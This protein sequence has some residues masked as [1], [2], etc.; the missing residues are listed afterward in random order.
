MISKK[1]GFSNEKPVF[2]SRTEMIIDRYYFGK[3]NNDEK[4]IY[5][6]IYNGI[7]EYRE[8]V[9]VPG[10]QLSN[11]LVGLIYYFVL[12]DNPFFFSIGEYAMHHAVDG[13]KIKITSLFSR[14]EEEAGRKK[15]EIII[16]DILYDPMIIRMN[17][18]EKEKYVHDY[19]IKNVK[20][21]HTHGNNGAFLNPYTVY[22]A[23]IEH[24]AVCEGI[25]KATKLLLNAM[26]IKCIVVSGDTD[27]ED[28]NHAWNIVKIGEAPY[29]LDVTYDMGKSLHSGFPH[30]DYFNLSDKVINRKIINQHLL[31]QCETMDM[32]Y[33]EKNRGIVSS[34]TELRTVF[35]EAINKR[36]SVV[37][38]K[39]DRSE[40]SEFKEEKSA[41]KL[42]ER[43]YF[44]V[45][46]GLGVSSSIFIDTTGFQGTCTIEITYS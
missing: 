38:I 14:E 41:K 30:Y 20:Y 26:N 39:I 7:K 4:K 3:L 11:K 1:A 40:Q 37:V 18:F 6:A 33:V 5:L 28:G 42:I 19:L 2:G 9:T 22:G 8:Y 25:S 44:N 36:E 43:L 29:H 46:R 27:D 13:D 32:N 12:L 15:I 23:F 31:P 16:N 34:E 35:E 24:K 21:D 10:V 17:D 45:A